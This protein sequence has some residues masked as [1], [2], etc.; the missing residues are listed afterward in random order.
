MRRGDPYHTTVCA[1]SIKNLLLAAVAASAFVGAVFVA[2]GPGAGQIDFATPS[3]A[4]VY[5]VRR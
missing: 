5:T 3:P 2:A 1:M 4:Q